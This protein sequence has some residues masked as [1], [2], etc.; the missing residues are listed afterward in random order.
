MRIQRIFLLVCVLI[1][2]GGAALLFQGP[3]P[4]GFT[5]LVSGIAGAYWFRARLK[6]TEAEEQPMVSLVALLDRPPSF[7]AGALAERLS[8]AWS[9]P[10]GA[11][12]EPGVPVRSSLTGQPPVFFAMNASGDLFM[13]YTQDRPLTAASGEPLPA[14]EPPPHAGWVSVARM[15]AGR[16]SDLPSAHRRIAQAVAGLADGSALGLYGSVS[17]RFLPWSDETR[18][19]LRE[20][21]GTLGEYF[22]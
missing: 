16:N 2:L 15:T 5:A 20:G 9:E 13:I 18:R 17:G 11:R 19:R 8:K 22:E 21:G 12:L 7:D 3:S 6:D 1:A 4:A 10:I 14:V